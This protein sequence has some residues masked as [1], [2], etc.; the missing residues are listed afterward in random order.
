MSSPYL[1]NGWASV[2]LDEVA[3]VKSG[4][5]P[6]RVNDILR[7][8]G[9]PW[10]R[11]GDMNSAGNEQEIT[12][13]SVCVP[14]EI[15]RAEGIETS[16]P[17]TII[18]PKAGGAIATNKKRRLAYPAAFDL[19][20][21]GI[22]P[23]Q[24]LTESRFLWWWIQ[25]LDLRDL[26]DGTVVPKINPHRVASLEIPLAPLAEQHRIVA[27][28]EQQLT[29]LDAAVASLKRAQANL[30]RYRASVLKAACEGR[31]VPPEADLARAEGRDYEEA[32]VLLARILAQR[33][34]Q[35]EEAQ[36]AKRRVKGQ[37]SLPG[38][39][40]GKYKEPSTPDTND[41]PQLPQGWAW[42]TWHQLSSRVTVGHVGPMK[43][44]YVAAGTPFLRSQNVRENRFDS[45]GLLYISARFHQQLSKSTLAPGDL[46][47]VRSGSVG[48]TCVIPPELGE[49]NCADLVI[50]KRPD[51]LV[52]KFGA[53][54]MN[55]LA[56][57]LI[58][59]GQVGVA[60]LHF[61]TKSVEALPVPLPPIAEQNRVVA[62]VDRRLSGIQTA[63]AAVDANLKRAERL[64]RAILKSAFEGRLVPQD[65]DDEPA[66]LL[67]ARIKAER[68]VQRA[69]RPKRASV[70]RGRRRNQP[71][72]PAA[73]SEA[74]ARSVEVEKVRP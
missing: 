19:N 5:T 34:E 43:H 46:V 60:L 65:P 54:Y 15:A 69:A 63:E 51:G 68:E 55:S 58:R 37:P 48:V 23:T 31:L 18:F 41:L 32:S 66:S 67:L 53:Y 36:Q 10:L 61:N 16:P 14:T 39:S 27:A 30:K 13:F 45:A 49:A 40:L 11:V 42:T 52:S 35:W 20:T 6:Q 50:I 62:E 33:R 59:E 22:I 17:G 9:I 26:D 56:R 73:V 38:L 70:T 1:P 28:I 4:R 24:L 57:R 72:E 7:D 47:V 12:T 44:E 21:M 71:V 29:R 2:P 64:R 3:Q 25:T 74:G 8:A